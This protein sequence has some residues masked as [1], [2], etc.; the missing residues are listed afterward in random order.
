MA[1]KC[2]H[3]AL[4]T[5]TFASRTLSPDMPPSSQ[6]L[7]RSQ[8]G[9]QAGAWLAAIPTEPATT[10]PPA[11]MQI[12]LRRRLR[13]PL[14]VYYCPA[15]VLLLVFR[16]VADCCWGPKQEGSVWWLRYSTLSELIAVL[17]QILS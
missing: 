1:G 6:A 10:L 12:A 7:L 11:A 15:L 16:I 13:Q 5:H 9:P 4:A 17:D 2:M 14:P 8:A 3:R